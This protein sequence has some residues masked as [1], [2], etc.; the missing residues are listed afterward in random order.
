MEILE[1]LKLNIHQVDLTEKWRLN[2]TEEKWYQI[3][4]WIPEKK[5]E[6]QKW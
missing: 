6:H 3:E 1:Y 4:N 2:Q 5:K